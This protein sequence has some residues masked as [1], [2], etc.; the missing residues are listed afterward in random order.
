M[1]L[2][3]DIAMKCLCTSLGGGNAT[4][5]PRYY[6]TGFQNGPSTIVLNGYASPFQLGIEYLVKISKA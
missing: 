5:T 3:D 6:E 2:N 4:L 1:P